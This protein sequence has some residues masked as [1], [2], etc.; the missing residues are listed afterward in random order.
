MDYQELVSKFPHLF[1]NQSAALRIVTNPDEVHDWQKH[2]RVELSQSGKPPG[3]ANIGVVFDDP[4]FVVLR[5][6]VEFPGGFRNGY[7]RLYARTYLEGGTAIVVILPEINGN[8]LLIHQF[9][10]ATRTWHWEIPRGFGEPGIASET[11][12]INEIREEING[13]V[14][15]IVDLGIFYHNAAFDGNP[16]NLY[17]A[18]LKS[19]GEPQIEEGIK[20]LNLFSIP[21]VEKMIAYGEITDGFTIVAYTRAKLKGLI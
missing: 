20:H 17:L 6:L 4:Y 1:S 10:H 3:W 11:Q 19:V 5:D 15:D 16:A 12:A 21:E 2:R 9:R 7:V 18:N 13:E 14:S 8:L